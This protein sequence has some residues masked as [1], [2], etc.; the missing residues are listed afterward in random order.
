MVL[1]SNILV[2][3]NGGCMKGGRSLPGG[4]TI[5]MGLRRFSGLG[6]INRWASGVDVLYWFRGRDCTG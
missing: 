6:R 1:L 3:G 2:I 4:L 5:R